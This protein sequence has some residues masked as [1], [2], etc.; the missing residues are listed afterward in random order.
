MSPERHIIYD[1]VDPAWAIAESHFPEYY[2]QDLELDDRSARAGGEPI[3]QSHRDI[4]SALFVALDTQISAEVAS[5]HGG[6][7]IRKFQKEIVIIVPGHWS[8]SL[9][10]LIL[11]VSPS[12]P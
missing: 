6:T 11:Q 8:D 4:L 7:P 10:H 12:P 2:I 3:A 1:D 5:M 9:Q